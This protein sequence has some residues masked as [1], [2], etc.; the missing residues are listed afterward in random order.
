MRRVFLLSNVLCL[1]VFFLVSSS[2]FAQQLL[3]SV[4][5]GDSADRGYE[6][7]QEVPRF[8]RDVPV[9]TA[10]AWGGVPTDDLFLKKAVL[11]SPAGSAYFG[12]DVDV[13]GNTAAVG[14]PYASGSG[15]VF[16]YTRAN[17][18]WTTSWTLAATI[19]GG[20][21]NDDFGM[22]VSLDGDTLVVGAP[23]VT[24]GNATLQGKVYV[25]EKPNGGWANANVG[26]AVASFSNPAADIGNYS[27]FGADVGLS[28][29][30]MVVEI[31]RAH[32]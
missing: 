24:V 26:N 28:G 9:R 31:G 3:V 29:N 15:Q 10:R 17:S 1:A 12:N 8:K 27:R 7:R 21:A 30:F 22:S 19:T 4:R 18:N 11:S 2:V 20:S 25:F 14:A 6:L 16:I 32:V 5:E 23:R 13:D